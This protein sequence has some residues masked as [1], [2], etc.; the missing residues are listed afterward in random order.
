M[1]TQ[2]INRIADHSVRLGPFPEANTERPTGNRLPKD[3]GRIRAVT[4]ANGGVNAGTTDAQMEEA[5]ATEDASNSSSL[6]DL[7]LAVRGNAGLSIG[8][9]GMEAL[10]LKACEE[11][12]RSGWAAFVAVCEALLKIREGRLF[13][14]R[15]E[16][17]EEYSR[18]QWQF[19]KSHAYRLVNAAKV[20]RLLSPIGEKFLPTCE[21]QIRPLVGLTEEQANLAWRNALEDAGEKPLTARLVQRHAAAVD[22]E[23]KAKPR[24]GRKS[25]RR[26]LAEIKRTLAELVD[27]VTI[28][29]IHAMAVEHQRRILELLR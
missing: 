2:K 17:F 8:L 1:R 4:A 5:H 16:T 22:P 11:T 6:D 25:R 28:T 21:S 13:R 3:N 24:T 27:L 12:I 29:E 10:D 9:S 19:G 20:I 7:N 15:F 23:R 14:E 26:A 18:Q